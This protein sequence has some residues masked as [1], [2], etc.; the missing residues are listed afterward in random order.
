M[1]FCQKCYNILVCNYHHLKTFP[2][3]STNLQNTTNTAGHR[4]V[5]SYWQAPRKETSKTSSISRSTS[6]SPPPW[7]GAK[8]HTNEKSHNKKEN[9][10]RKK[11]KLKLRRC[12]APSRSRSIKAPAQQSQ[13]LVWSSR[14]PMRG[15]CRGRWHQSHLRYCSLRTES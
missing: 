13:S 2:L 5:T 4:S 15:L 11:N 1:C 3:T 12:D 6:F 14:S 8:P 7:T 9:E 10:R